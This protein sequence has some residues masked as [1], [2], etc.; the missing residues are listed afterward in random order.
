MLVSGAKMG[1]RGGHAV[2]L[3]VGQPVFIWLQLVQ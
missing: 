1:G 3:V 2:S